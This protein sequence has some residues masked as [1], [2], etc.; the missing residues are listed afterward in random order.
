MAIAVFAEMLAVLSKCTRRNNRKQ[1]LQKPRITSLNG[2]KLQ[3]APPQMVGITFRHIQNDNKISNKLQSMFLITI[4]Q[5]FLYNLISVD[6]NHCIKK[7]CDSQR[8]SY[9]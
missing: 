4:S 9:S 3:G 8:K 7:Y 1:K 5:K 2:G 6:T